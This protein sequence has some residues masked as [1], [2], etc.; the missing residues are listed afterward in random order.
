MDWTV[1]FTKWSRFNSSVF[2]LLSFLF[3]GQSNYFLKK[4]QIYFFM[5]SLQN[6][7]RNTPFD[8][9][10]PQHPE[11]DVFVSS[12]ANVRITVYNQK[13]LWQPEVGVLVAC[14]G[15]GQYLFYFFFLSC[16]RQSCKNHDHDTQQRPPPPISN[17]TSSIASNPTFT[18]LSQSIRNLIG[19]IL[20]VD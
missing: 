6:N 7:T 2:V 16:H 10:S 18:G 1:K 14:R 8:Q 13:S 17:P 4:K 20:L 3:L 15:G 5:V 19:H 12:Q 11:V 9:N